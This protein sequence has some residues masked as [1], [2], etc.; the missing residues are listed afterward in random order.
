MLAE[1]EFCHLHEDGIF[2]WDSSGLTEEQILTVKIFYV[3]S[4][5]FPFMLVTYCK[6]ENDPLWKQITGKSKNA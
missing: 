6:R 2:E 3:K 4:G 5:F 1:D